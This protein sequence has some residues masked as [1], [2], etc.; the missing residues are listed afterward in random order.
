MNPILVLTSLFFLSNTV[1]AFYKDYVIYG[2]LFLILTITSVL[3]H[4]TYDPFI[5]KVDKLAIY[6]VV[7][8]GAYHMIRH[9]SMEQ[10]FHAIIIVGL[11]FSTIIMYH[12]GQETG[13]MCFDS[14]H[15]IACMYHGVMHIIGSIGHHLIFVL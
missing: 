14:N 9:L 15:N 6:A 4:Y 12:Y 11:F 1:V 8:Y 10:W 5:R 2:I 13:T 3:T 7:L